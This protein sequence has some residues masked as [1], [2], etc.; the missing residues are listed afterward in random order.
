MADNLLNTISGAFTWGPINSRGLP[1]AFAKS[2]LPVAKTRFPFTVETAGSKSKGYR[3]KVP[4]PYSHY[5]LPINRSDGLPHGRSRLWGDAGIATQNRVIDEILA[6]AGARGWNSTDTA[7]ALAVA[8]TESGFN[9][10]A[11]AS[12]TSA[13]GIGQ[14]I[15]KTGK[16]FGLSAENC[17]SIPL[18]ISAML[19]LI[20]EN[21]ALAKRSEY[22]GYLSGDGLALQYALYH[23]GPSLKYGG[24]QIAT[25]RVVPWAKKIYQ[26]LNDQTAGSGKPT[27]GL[28]R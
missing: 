9:P 24:M 27:G 14:L 19:S 17:F 12:S 26:W 25:S 3:P 11:A 7:F 5:N 1:G 18:N 8:R 13:C 10:D 21:R 22:G 16:S 6:Q 2:P 23:D 20:E 4:A 15:D 28:D